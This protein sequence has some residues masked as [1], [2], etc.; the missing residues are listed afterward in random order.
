MS[1]LDWIVLIATLAGIVAYGLYKS[2]TTKNLEGYFLN[3]RTMPWYLVLLSIMG[4]Q[5]SAI[6]FISVPGQAFTDGMRFVQ[7]Y[8]G[9]PLAMIVISISF[10]PIFKK[11][12]VFTAYEFLEQRFDVKTRTFTS[13]LFLLSRGVSTGISI[14]APSIILSSLLGW[15]IFWTN[16]VMGGI[17]I[18]YTFSGGAKAVA[19]TQQLQLIIIFSAMFIAGYYIV[20]NIPSDISFS[21]ALKVS[22]A[23][24]KLN[25]ITTGMTDKGFEWKDRFNLINGLIAGFFLSLSYFGTDQSQVGRYLTAKDTTESRLG[26]LMNGIVKVPM[27]FLILLLGAL[28]FTYY[29]FNT[30]PIFFNKVVDEKVYTSAYR[31][32]LK[33]VQQQFDEASSKQNFY[34]TKYVNALH[35]NNGNVVLYRDS[36]QKTNAQVNVLRAQYKDILK[37]A[38]GTTDTN[39]TNY[40]FIRYV[41]DNL[42]R[43]LVGLLIAVI[44]LAS[45]GSLAAALN[46]LASCTMI[47]F[48]CRIKKHQPHVK[49]SDLQ[50]E[51][52]Y[53]L[54]K[55]FTLGWGIFCII[56]AQFSLNMGSLIQ[57]VNEYGSLFYGAILGIFLVAFYMKKIQGTAVFYSAMI[58]E[59]IVVTIYLLD[60]FG[61]IGF[62]FLWLNVV[63]AMAVVVLSWV[64]QKLMPVK[65]IQR[66]KIVL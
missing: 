57:A 20:H 10:V 47:D 13:F 22:G 5:A 42:P 26:L 45:W 44:F 3:N 24:G 48:Y 52:H 63:G 35:N 17:L 38:D 11:L 43:G 15:N 27:Q 32:S 4:T 36:L 21:D 33:M 66:E 14:Y 64:M 61:I 53:Y 59:V 51:Q 25:V 55:W 50:E 6:T 49:V 40:I 2:R 46:S 7:N 28:L 16:I 18:I 39:D 41:V 29:Q 34:A 12:K 19:Y 58:S 65:Q 30:G 37:K 62:G 56:V 54:S 60:K 1:N 9:L 31:D 23:S 8:F